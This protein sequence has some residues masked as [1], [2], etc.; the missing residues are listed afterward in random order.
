MAK[1]PTKSVHV[2]DDFRDNLII[3]RFDP[4][5][6]GMRASKLT[7]MKSENSEDAITWNVF[8]SLRQIT[9]AAWLPALWGEAHSE[10]AP[11]Y[12]GLATYVWRSIAPPPSLVITG[13]EGRSEIDVLIETP[14]WV[15]VIE[16]KYTSDISERTTSRSDR[17]QVIRN[18]DV[19][20]YFAGTRDFYFSL[21]VKDEAH[22]PRGA[23]AVGKYSDLGGVRAMLAGHRPDGLPN[24]KSVTLITWAQLGHTL[25]VATQKAL[26]AAERGYAERALAWLKAKGL[27]AD[28]A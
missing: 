6:L 19:G 13:D 18:I 22:S 27:A 26:F 16:A 12:D 14:W 2:A 10:S 20:S 1:L 21:L 28:A 25:H 9:P 4:L 3:D 24:L 15:W 11:R 5:F 17:D 8:R 23:K 7:H